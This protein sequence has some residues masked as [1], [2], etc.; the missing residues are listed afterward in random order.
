MLGPEPG[1]MDARIEFV[2]QL[3]HSLTSAHNYFGLFFLG[4]VAANLGKPTYCD[5]DYQE[6]LDYDCR[7][8]GRIVR[9]T[10]GLAI[11]TQKGR[12]T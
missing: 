2:D 12:I 1:G 7:L 4:A 6:T 10:F 8:L 9:R 5:C 11:C 3:L